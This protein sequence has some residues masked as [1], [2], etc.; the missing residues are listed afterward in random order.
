MPHNTHSH[1][2]KVI[3]LS[4]LA[5]IGCQSWSFSVQQIQY[6]C[7]C[8]CSPFPAGNISLGVNRSSSSGN[9]NF[10]N[11]QTDRILVPYAA[12]CYRRQRMCVREWVMASVHL[13]AFDKLHVM[14]SSLQYWVSPHKGSSTRVRFFIRIAKRFRARF[15]YKEF[16]FLSIL[17]TPIA[18]ACQHISGKICR[19][20][21]CNPTC[22]GNTTWNRTRNR[23]MHRT[24]RRTLR[25][26]HCH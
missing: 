7:S 14:P 21:I 17:W 22:A 20:L 12:R 11:E 26:S 4:H 15:A 25:Q 24:C 1:I 8:C 23:T 16:M 13:I 18:T 6:P 10:A 3:R 9:V 2:S 19:K 5:R